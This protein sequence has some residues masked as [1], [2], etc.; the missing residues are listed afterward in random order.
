[1]RRSAAFTIVLSIG[2]ASQALAQA[3]GMPSFNAPY[4]AFNRA[5]FGASL[6]FADFDNGTGVEGM[7]RFASRQFDIGLRGG[8]F[9][10]GGGGDESFLAG[11]EA[12]YR[13]ITHN[14]N[15]PLDGALI[16]G[17][18]GAFDGG[19]QFQF[20]VGLSL[21]RRLEVANSQVSIVPYVQPT[22]MLVNF[23]VP[24]VLGGGRDTDVRFG[25]GVGGDF[26]LSPAFDAR[27]SLG[28][29][30][31]EGISIAAVWLR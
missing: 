5:E 4:R 12:R 26:R 31:I 30:D 28:F 6:S 2:L 19:S 8:I 23:P 3:T 22:L 18:G 17:G 16:F 27:V 29:G 13:V 1:M 9:F 7:Y 11:V 10:P 15:F 25:F 20:P 14:V 21:G 24:A